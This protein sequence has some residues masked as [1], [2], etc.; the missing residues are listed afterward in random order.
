MKK[1]E[2]I[3][4]IKEEI[5]SVLAREPFGK[6]P[7][8]PADQRPAD[9]RF[10]NI[11]AYLITVQE[12]TDRVGILQYFEDLVNGKL[13]RTGLNNDLLMEIE[14]VLEHGLDFDKFRAQEKLMDHLKYVQKVGV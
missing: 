10:P 2:L 14:E 1:S 13:P 4:I 6:Y 7:N 8:I 11:I 5:S 3:K 9:E 12:Q